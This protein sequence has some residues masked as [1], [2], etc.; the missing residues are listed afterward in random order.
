MVV[1]S[2]K[3][4]EICYVAFSVVVVV[5]VGELYLREKKSNRLSSQMHKFELSTQ[6]LH[7]IKIVA[8]TYIQYTS[9]HTNTQSRAYKHILIYTYQLKALCIFETHIITQLKFHYNIYL[10]HNMHFNI[11][12]LT[13]VSYG[14]FA[15]SCCYQ[16][17]QL[18]QR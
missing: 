17:T 12:T 13:C 1:E 2:M 4:E 8:H 16:C 11:S 5:V 18:I 6:Q 14:T 3:R 7:M 10:L 15:S 9:T